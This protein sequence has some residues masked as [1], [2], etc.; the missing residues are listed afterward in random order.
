MSGPGWYTPGE[1]LLDLPLI[2]GS[3]VYEAEKLCVNKGWHP[4]LDTLIDTIDWHVIRG[5]MEPVKV[6]QIKEKFGTL[7]FY[8]GGGDEHTHYL[9]RFAE[10]LSGRVCEDCGAAAGTRSLKGWYRTVCDDHA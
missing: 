2:K 9:V 6:L 7:R 8:Y 10:T 5:K 4:I 3:D 1:E